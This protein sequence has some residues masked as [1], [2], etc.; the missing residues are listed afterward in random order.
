MY[1]ASR[2]QIRHRELYYDTA[3]EAICLEALRR[4]GVHAS[5]ATHPSDTITDKDG[6]PAWLPDLKLAT[7]NWL[8]APNG[9][10]VTAY[11]ECKDFRRSFG[12]PVPDEA[13][14]QIRRSAAFGAMTV[15]VLPR[16]PMVASGFA[17]WGWVSLAGRHPVWRDLIFPSLAIMDAFAEASAIVEPPKRYRR[18]EAK[19]Q[20]KLPLR[21][22]GFAGPRVAQNIRLPSLS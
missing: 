10:P 3:H 7:P 5:K 11:V 9:S 18:W 12:D 1:V 14:T 16:S 15:I 2:K 4:V 6:V 20:M 8:Q 19:E 17:W 21:R 22:R 13:A